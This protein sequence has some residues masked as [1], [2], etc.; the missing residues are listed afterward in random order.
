MRIVNLLCISVLLF[1]AAG[2]ARAEGP[3][4]PAAS[5]TVPSGDPPAAIGINSPIGWMQ[6][7]FAASLYVRAADH[8]AIRANFALY[9]NHE[10]VTGTLAGGDEMG[11]T[12]QILDLGIGWVYY[13]DRVLHGF[14]LE[15]GAL[16]RERNISTFDGDATAEQ[17]DLDTRVYAV[18]GLIGWSWVM[19][20]VFFLS[21][22]V[23]VSVGYETGTEHAHIDSPL[24]VTT[25]HVSRVAV[26][27]EA[28]LRMGIVFD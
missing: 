10:S 24:M 15:A 13:P 14:M 16:R 17:V 9:N 12:G 25:S 21:T 19:S 5:P 7:G 27:G 22:G 28:Y 4:A 2:D 23:G 20:D 8:H 18:R 6:D 26:T 11:H 1:V 3:P